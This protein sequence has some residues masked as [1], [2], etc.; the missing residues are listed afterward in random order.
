MFWVVK[1]KGIIE[2]YTFRAINL[3]ELY[4][5]Y[6]GQNVSIDI[7]GDRHIIIVRHR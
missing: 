2:A 4:K 7:D 1:M 3:N 6:E 5:R